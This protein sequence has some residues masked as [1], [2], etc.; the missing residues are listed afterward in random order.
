MG[1][2]T[3]KAT[4]ASIPAFNCVDGS[5]IEN[6]S[7]L[8]TAL[9]QMSE[10]SY[11]FHV[12]AERNDFGTWVRDVFNAHQLADTLPPGHSREQSVISVLKY[13]LQR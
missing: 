4:K 1:K 2:K 11:Y 5:T 7:Q 12:N 9:E 8:A 10:D 3:R 13:M 6:I